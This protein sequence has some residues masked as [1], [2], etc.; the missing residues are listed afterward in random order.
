[1]Q[2]DDAEDAL[3]VLLQHD[4]VANGAEIIAEMQIAGGLD[5][6]E[7]AVHLTSLGSMA[8]PVSA[9]ASCR[10]SRLPAQPAEEVAPVRHTEGE[11]KSGKRGEPGT[12]QAGERADAHRRRPPEGGAERE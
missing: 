3:I 2:I 8:A 1:M 5:A 4:P 12:N 7:N 9:A 10:S 6:G 11:R